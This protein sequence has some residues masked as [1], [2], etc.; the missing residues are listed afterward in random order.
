MLEVLKKMEWLGHDAFKIEAGGKVIYTDPF[1]LRSGL[2]KADLI[3][4]THEHYDHCSPEDVAMIAKD[5]TVIISP[6]DCG[7]KL[8]GRVMKVEPGVTIVE[9][10]VE[11]RTVRAY[12]TNK[13]FHPKANNWVGYIFTVEEQKIYIAGDTDHIPEMKDYRCDIALLPV[14]GTYVMTAE[15][16]ARAATDIRPKVAV[17]M[18][19]G[20]IVGTGSDAERFKKLYKGETF[21]FNKKE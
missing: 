3:L 15:E 9:Q 12:N 14:S 4:I 8:D 10:G 13:T 2:P 7:G 5:D 6:G 1:R 18:H 20:S 17:P 16:A 21:I 19:Y 11:V